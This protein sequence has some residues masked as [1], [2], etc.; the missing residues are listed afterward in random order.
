MNYGWGKSGLSVNILTGLPVPVDSSTGTES[1][2]KEIVILP[3]GVGHTIVSLT[4]G[5]HPENTDRN[6]EIV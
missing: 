1:K 2:S 5:L 4:F 6:L 3:H